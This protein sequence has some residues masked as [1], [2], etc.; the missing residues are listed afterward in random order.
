MTTTRHGGPLTADRVLQALAALG[1][2][3]VMLDDPTPDDLPA[4]LG[5]LTASV[6]AGLHDHASDVHEIEQFAEGYARQL[7]NDGLGAARLMDA[8]LRVMAFQ[9]RD[10]TMD[11][12]A[13]VLPLKAAGQAAMAASGLIGYQ[14]L[15]MPDST[16]RPADERF[17]RELLRGARRFLGEARRSYDRLVAYLKG[18]GF[19][20]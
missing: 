17:Q 16:G 1:T 12:G 15:S 9:L 5:Q 20:V 2:P 6:E 14:L 10:T 7:D 8:R 19:N 3:T 11:D 13:E 4:L 18:R